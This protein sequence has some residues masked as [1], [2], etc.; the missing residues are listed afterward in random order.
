[1]TI[2]GVNDVPV[3]IEKRTQF[4]SIGGEVKVP[5]YYQLKSGETLTQL[6]ERAGGLTVMLLLTGRFLPESRRAANNS[7]TWTKQ[8]KGWSLT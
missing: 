5:G 2:F 4:V 7:P 3:P 6:I 8:S 1:M